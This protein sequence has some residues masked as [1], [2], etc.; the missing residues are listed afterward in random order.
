MC[1]CYICQL[2]CA[3]AAF[4]PCA[5]P[6][7]EYLKDSI[8]SLVRC[9]C[10]SVELWGMDVVLCGQWLQEYACY[11]TSNVTVDSSTC[12]VT[13]EEGEVDSLVLLPVSTLAGDVM[14]GVT[15]DR[16]C[17]VMFDAVCCC[18][19]GMCWT[20]AASQC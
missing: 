3:T 14:E 17:Y 6:V 15:A 13:G 4:D 7:M 10:P 20:Q 9:I 18:S 8:C 11:V 19:P 12:R 1:T 16:L 5:L 2:R